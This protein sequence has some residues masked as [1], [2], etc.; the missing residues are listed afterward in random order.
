[1]KMLQVIIAL[2]SVVTAAGCGTTAGTYDTGQKPVAAS[3]AAYKQRLSDEGLVPLSG[4]EIDTLLRGNN[5]Q[6]FDGSWTW[7]FGEDG[8][9]ASVAADGSWNNNSQRW[10]IQGDK[11]CRSVRDTFPCVS[12]FEADGVV[13]FGKEGTN[14]LETW[15][16][17]S[18]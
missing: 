1:M 7:D 2:I 6:A 9:A 4:S 17:V 12:I 18:R 11:L 3:E 16:I 14:Q 5:F 8:L 15:A 13:R 10:E